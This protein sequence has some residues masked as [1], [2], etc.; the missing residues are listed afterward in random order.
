MD[1][2]GAEK[3]LACTIGLVERIRTQLPKAKYAC[4]KPEGTRCPILVYTPADYE[5]TQAKLTQANIQATMTGKRLRISPNTFNNRE[6]IDNLLFA[7]V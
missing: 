4:I 3:M 5:G 7:L 6:D 2:I 1:T